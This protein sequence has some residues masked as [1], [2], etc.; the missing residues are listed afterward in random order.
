MGKV[1]IRAGEGTITAGENFLMPP[2]LLTNLEIQ[3]FYENKPKFNGILS[4][5]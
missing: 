4:F 3:E 2:Q 5:N 1:T